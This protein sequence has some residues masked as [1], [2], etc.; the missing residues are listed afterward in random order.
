MVVKLT[1]KAKEKLRELLSTKENAKM[2]RL[3]V[4][5]YG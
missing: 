5:G 1:D 3:Y 2:L 4:V